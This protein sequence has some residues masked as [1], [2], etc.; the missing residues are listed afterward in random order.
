MN[1]KKKLDPKAGLPP[2][3]DNIHV[4][5]H[6]IQR[7]SLKPLGQSKP[8]FMWSTLKK[9]GMKLGM[10]YDEASGRGAVQSILIMTLG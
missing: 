5:Y 6:N 10:I 1:L 9:G 7:S 4:Y 8:N 3:R 2:P